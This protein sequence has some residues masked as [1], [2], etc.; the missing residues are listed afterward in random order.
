MGVVYS[1]RDPDLDRR[2]AL[3][4]LRPELSVEPG[5]RARLLREARAMAQLSHPNVVPIYDVGVLGDQVFIA[6]E[7]VDGVTLRHKLDRKTPWRT[8]VRT[9]LQA[10]RG[11]AA[12]H[13]AG[14]VHRDFKPDNVLYGNDGRIRVVDFGLVSVD[15]VELAPPSSHALG[16]GLDPTVETTAGAVLGTPAYMAPEAMRGELT[17]ARADQFSF[18]VALFHGLYGVYPHTG[19]TLAERAEQIAR[20]M[21]ARPVGSAVPERVYRVLVR[22][23]CARPESR[24]RSMEALANALEH[25]ISPRQRPRLVALG[26]AG[27]AVIVALVAFAVI[28]GR[29]GRTLPPLGFGPP[30]TIARSDDQQLAVTML[31]DGRYLR[32]ERGIITVVAANGASSH[33]LT[34]PVG[35]TPTRVRPSSVDGQVEVYAT[36]V[37][38]S[39]WLVPVDGGPWRLLL[40]DPSCASEVD[41]SPDGTQL[42]ITRGGELHIRNLATG[43]ERTLLRKAYGPAAREGSI[44]SWSP[45]GKRI[46]VSGEIS[47]VDINSSQ[48]IHHGR[49]GAAACWLDA[50]RVAYVTRTWLRNEIH[51]I[52]LRTGTDYL[53]LETEGA[54]S[55]LAASRG[56]LLVRRDE[57]HSRVYV[58]AASETNLTSVEQLAQLDT[59]SAVDFI[60]AVWTPDGAVI[61]LA[62][63]AGQRGLMRTVPGQRGTPLVLHRTR[64]IALRG[65]TH[66]H[67]IYSFND[68]D[69]CEI[70]IFDLDTGKDQ[71]W[72]SARCTQMPHITCAWS[73]SRCVVIDAAGTRWFDPASMQFMG[74]AP[75]FE[76]SE[77]LSP[78]ATMS[79]RLRG[80]AVMRNLSSG[81]ETTVE[82]PT[83]G[84]PLYISWGSDSSTLLAITSSPGHHRMMMRSRDGRWRTII[85]E[86]H[87][88]LNGYAISPDGSQVA[89]IALL[90]ASTW[91]YLP[92][93]ATP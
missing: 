32:V 85:D 14:L 52:D 28:Q 74:P 6:M 34:T 80:G 23:L 62:A 17:D 92:F 29:S 11:L 4:V 83:A 65:N 27:A 22:G 86:P 72:R 69:D 82:L 46:V 26:A 70:R 21:I 33:P 35:R 36:G 1:A 19:D 59:G 20:G 61:T 8:V 44:P 3:K 67:V 71:F 47:I 54:I 57:F 51:L 12:A 18:C 42:A 88:S 38:C 79:V 5:S 43:E 40:E 16:S 73:P 41:L 45:D 77:I 60:P 13:A 68:G 31:R 81:V 87:R 7:L 93:N 56:G 55:D 37:P 64:D 58:I 90:S 25:A 30:E 63:V 89:F 10:A 66:R 84:G 48:E 53:V 76:Q 91:L 15:P 78:D 39:W 2:V 50:D 49:L 75:R 9:Y 24:Y